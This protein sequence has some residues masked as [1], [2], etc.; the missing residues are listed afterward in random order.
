VRFDAT[1]LASGVYYYRL[2]IND[3]EFQQVKKMMLLK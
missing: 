2:V 3:G 1:R